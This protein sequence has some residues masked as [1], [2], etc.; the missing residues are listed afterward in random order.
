MITAAC[1][2]SLSHAS[3]AVTI[4][5]K[6]LTA[7]ID[8]CSSDSFIDEYLAKNMNLKITAASK[9]IFMA[10]TTLK[11]NILGNCIVDIV[12]NNQRYSDVR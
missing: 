10:Q 1:P 2:T 9:K 6:N 11:S 8:L 5:G 7:L 4:N 3:V 12:L